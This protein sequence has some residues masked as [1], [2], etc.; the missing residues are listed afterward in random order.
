MVLLDAP[1]RL[2]DK[3]DAAGGEVAPAV[4]RVEDPA[5]EVA[6]ES[7]DR[8]VAPRRVGDEIVGEGHLGMAAEGPHVPAERGDLEAAPAGEA[9]DGAVLQ[10]RRHGRDAG[11]L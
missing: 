4:E 8:E 6:A 10:P 2:A 11:T 5:F 9:G 7:V 1:S 3:A